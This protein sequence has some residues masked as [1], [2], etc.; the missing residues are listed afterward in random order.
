MDEFSEKARRYRELAREVLE[1]D[2]RA[3]IIKLAGE[4]DQRARATFLMERL[5][6]AMGPRF[7]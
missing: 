4:Y 6:G 7:G 3:E 2:V 5:Q 1:D